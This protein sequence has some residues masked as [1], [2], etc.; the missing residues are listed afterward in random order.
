M[1]I[2]YLGIWA[3]VDMV[4]GVLVSASVLVVEEEEQEEKV[5]L[6]WLRRRRQ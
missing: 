4:L 3:Y 2:L 6:W 1:Y 5:F